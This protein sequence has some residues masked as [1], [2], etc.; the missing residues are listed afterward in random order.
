MKEILAPLVSANEDLANIV[1]VKVKNNNFYNKGQFICTLETSKTSIEVEL[2][3]DGY[4][5]F[6]MKKNEEIKSGEILAIQSEEKISEKDINKYTSNRT[7]NK[8]HIN[9]T[10]TK[11]AQSLIN[12]HKIDL[13]DIKKDGLVKESDVLEFIKKNKKDDSQNLRK[14]NY[15]ELDKIMQISKIDKP[16]FEDIKRLKQTLLN[17]QQVYKDQWN[18]TVPSLEAIFSRWETGKAYSNNDEK[19]NISHLSYIVGNV[20]LGKNVYV[21]PFT[22]LDGGGNLIIGDNTSI[23]AGVQ[24]YSHDSISRTLSGHSSSTIYGQTNIGKSCFI[25]P[26]TIITRG[27]KI[28]DH[29]FVGAGSVVTFDVPS[30]TAVAGSPAD[31]IGKVKINK[32][33]TVNISRERSY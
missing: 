4:V 21:G 19:T 28:G 31:I 25:G 2:E 11:K 32:D 22:F 16:D 23:A 8:K 27:V 14:K 9:L 6:L 3:E 13:R 15:V 17:A 26:N 18:R 33:G 1:D 24:I 10:V 12:S 29:C 7:S 30:F 5:Y 20:K